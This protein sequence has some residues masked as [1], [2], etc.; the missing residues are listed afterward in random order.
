M[1]VCC[2]LFVLEGLQ[3]LAPVCNG[4]DQLGR[5]GGFWGKPYGEIYRERF[6]MCGGKLENENISMV[7]RGSST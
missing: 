7:L 3:R 1:V 6:V 5:F 2:F 4:F